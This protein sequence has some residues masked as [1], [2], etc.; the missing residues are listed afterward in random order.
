MKIKN[1]C[2][3]IYCNKPIDKDTYAY[4]VVDDKKIKIAKFCKYH[5]RWFKLWM[6]KP[7]SSRLKRLLI[8]K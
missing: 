1:K 8:E 2:N 3:V 5:G 6:D 7:F 4:V